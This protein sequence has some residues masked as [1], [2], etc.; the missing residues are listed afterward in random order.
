M[1]YFISIVLMVC[2]VLATGCDGNRGKATSA[3]ILTGTKWK[4]SAWSASSSDPSRLTIT[5]DFR[6]SQISGTSAVNSYSGSYTATA[7]GAFWVKDLQSTLVGSSDD[8]MHTESVYFDLLRQARKYKANETTL[9]LLDGANNDILTFHARSKNDILSVKN[10]YEGFLMDIPGVVGVGIGES[11]GNEYIVVMAEKRTPQVNK[12]VPKQLE[13]F[14]VVVEVTRPIEPLPSDAP[15]IEGR[16][17]ALDQE[18]RW[19]RVEENPNDASGSAKAVLQVNAGTRIVLSNVHTPSRFSDLRVGYLIQA[20]VTA[21]VA[22]SYPVQA[23][24]SVILYEP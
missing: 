5:A 1:R 20:W 23:T 9:T 13:E 16:I 17:T 7:D 8:A 24:A 3:E 2:A 4:L 18:Q 11:D 6:E 12:D 21:L 15:F 19:I 14:P 10:R 22:E